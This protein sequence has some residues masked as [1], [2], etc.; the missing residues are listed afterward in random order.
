MWLQVGCGSGDR[1]WR[2]APRVASVSSG[3][4]RGQLIS[5]DI[6][7]GGVGK[8]TTAEKLPG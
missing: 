6:W 4:T 7:A 5:R 8:V 2:E 1:K 3:K